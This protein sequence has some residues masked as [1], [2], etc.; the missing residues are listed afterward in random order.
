MIHYGEEPDEASLSYHMPDTTPSHGPVH[1]LVVQSSLHRHTHK[2]RL[3]LLR[4]EDTDDFIDEDVD[5]DHRLP[6][7]QAKATIGDDPGADSARGEHMLCQRRR[8]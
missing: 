3:V 4:G 8:I 5:A 7:S 2:R 6:M 1:Y